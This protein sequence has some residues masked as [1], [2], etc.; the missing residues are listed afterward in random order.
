MS[1]EARW[2]A[3]STDVH[4]I[5]W[6]DDDLPVASALLRER[7]DQV[8]RAC[9][10]FRPDS[11]LMNLRGGTQLVSQLL[12]DLIDTAL[13]AAEMTDGA[14]DPTLGQAM[15]RAGYDRT[16][17][18]LPADGPKA[19]LVPTRYSWRDV[20][21]DGRLLTL[22][23]GVVLDLGATAKAWLVDDVAATLGSLGIS[24]L[25]N[26]GGDLSPAGELPP[27]GWTVAVGD[28]GMPVD[29][30]SVVSPMATSST[31]RRT[32][33]RAGEVLHHVLDPRTGAPAEPYWRTVTVCAA[34][35]VDANTASTASIVFGADAVAW[36]RDRHL[37]S[38]LVRSDA[39][40]VHVAGW[41]DREE[42]AA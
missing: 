34:S 36:L 13:R 10:R 28:P 32:W 37:P 4:L 8:D 19:L 25:V 31:G 41:P 14:V 7:M 18:E 39:R 16:L 40:A 5:T 21:L 35:C 1:A 26:V 30:V 23:D 20:H 38:R 3:W 6:Q 29:V 12:A 22:P 15:V 24:A 33:R 11:E 27:G 2:K 17:A 9:S 42:S